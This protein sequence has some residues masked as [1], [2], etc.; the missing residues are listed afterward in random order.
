MERFLTKYYMN[1]AEDA[2]DSFVEKLKSEKGIG[3]RTKEKI[4]KIR[5]EVFCHGKERN[6]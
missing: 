2:L 5:N 6:A 3:P 1:A 4:E